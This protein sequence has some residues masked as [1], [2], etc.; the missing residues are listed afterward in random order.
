M[1][2]GGMDVA[3]SAHQHNGATRKRMV[4]AHSAQNQDRLYT[5]GRRIATT[6]P[7]KSSSNCC[8]S[9][10]FPAPP[11][12]PP[13]LPPTLPTP[14]L[15]PLPLHL[16]TDVIRFHVF[17]LGVSFRLPFSERNRQLHPSFARPFR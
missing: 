10:S 3:P 7:R 1:G 4:E 2:W 11:S 17:V 8:Y 15:T 5:T 16:R 14:P 13:P 12:S 9:P 6:M